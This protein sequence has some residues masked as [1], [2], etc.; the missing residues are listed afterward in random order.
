[1]LQQLGAFAKFTH[2]YVLYSTDQKI[3]WVALILHF[4]FSIFF[5]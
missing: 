2:T 1:M 4:S 3:Y 5:A